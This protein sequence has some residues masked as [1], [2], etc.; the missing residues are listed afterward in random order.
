MIAIR[1]MIPS[2]LT[3]A[4]LL[5]GFLA[6]VFT[7]KGEPEAAVLLIGAGLICD[8]F[9]GYFARR[10]DATSALGRELDSL[11]DLVTFGIA[12]AL[13]IYASSLHEVRVL[14]AACCIVYVC[15]CA[16]RLAR[17]NVSQSSLAGFV[18]MPTPLAA[19]LALILTDLAGP[20]PLAAFCL[21][22]IASLTVSRL[23]FPAFKKAKPEPAEDC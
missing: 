6:V 22:G 13:L 12:P 17:F 3:L 1:K 14:G 21:L 16:L 11:A 20:A 9:D 7:F 4:N 15:C 5:L 23:T 18:G 19:V 2:A 8:F 10:L